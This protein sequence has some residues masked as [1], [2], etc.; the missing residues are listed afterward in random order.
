MKA[1]VTFLLSLL[2]LCFTPNADAQ[3]FNNNTTYSN[4]LSKTPS[5]YF[6]SKFG[7]VFSKS[8]LLPSPTFVSD[9]L[10]RLPLQSLM[11]TTLNK[12]APNQNFSTQSPT[13]FFCKIELQIE[14][15]AKIPFK[16]RIGDIRYVDY[17]ENK[18]HIKP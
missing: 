11:H 8:V 10:Y 17:L 7:H 14:K 5:L 16:F 15:A 3:V 1:Q 2:T 18:T 13:P 12:D 9:S 4:H 6:E